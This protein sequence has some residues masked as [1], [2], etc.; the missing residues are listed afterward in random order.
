MESEG[1]YF[2]VSDVHLGEAGDPTGQREQRFLAFLRSLPPD[3]RGLFLLGDIFDFWV[4]YHDVVPRGF[5]RVLGELAR[6]SDAG[7]ELWYFCGNHDWWMTDYFRKELSARVITEPY[8]ILEVGGLTLCVGHGD[9]V[10]RRPFRARLLT[11]L[12]HSRILIALL[13]ALHPRIVFRWARR[14]SSS[15]RHGHPAGYRFRGEEEPL[16]RFADKMARRKKVD[17]CIFGHLHTPLEIDLSKRG[18]LYVLGDWG[19]GANY[20]NLSGM[21]ISGFGLPKMEK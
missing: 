8:R 12:F 10:G 16:Y 9:A 13:R 15:S 3:T 14:W 20:L 7:V 18:T 19:S 17:A 5:V 4:D 21:Y 11:H 2:F 1:R 6:L